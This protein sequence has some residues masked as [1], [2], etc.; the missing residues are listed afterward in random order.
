MGLRLNS[1]LSC[2]GLGASVHAGICPPSVWSADT[3]SGA[4]VGSRC[5]GCFLSSDWFPLVCGHPLTLGTQASLRPPLLVFRELQ[6]SPPSLVQRAGSDTCSS[7]KGGDA[8]TREGPSRNTGAA[9]GQLWVLLREHSHQHLRSSAE[10]SPPQTEDVREASFFP[11]RRPPD[12]GTPALK[13]TQ[14]RLCP[15]PSLPSYFSAPNYKSNSQSLLSQ[16]QSLGAFTC[17][18]PLCLAKQ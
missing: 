16:S 1:S 14:A 12:H 7:G 13:T 15:D 9:L 11:E 4:C 2:L 17:C 3:V 18:D 5:C 10:V 6:P 8:E